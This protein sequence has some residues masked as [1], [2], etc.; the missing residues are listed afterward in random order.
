MSC[1]HPVS[2]VS[3]DRCKTQKGSDSP[4]S[5]V[6]SARDPS[7]L[8]GRV[9]VTLRNKSAGLKYH[10]SES[11]F[12]QLSPHKDCSTPNSIAY[13]KAD[14]SESIA[15]IGQD[16]L[17]RPR[18]RLNHDRVPTAFPNNREKKKS[19]SFRLPMPDTIKGDRLRPFPTSGLP[20]RIDPTSIGRLGQQINDLDKL[21]AVSKVDLCKGL[22]I[23]ICPPP[24]TKMVVHDFDKK[25]S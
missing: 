13:M 25:V 3:Q 9:R 5:R 8:Q 11:E 4:S 16:S 20:A 7:T 19:R 21:S 2:R 6:G 23:G 10:F 14:L 22:I 12:G 15:L 18:L 17:M 24:P 1:K